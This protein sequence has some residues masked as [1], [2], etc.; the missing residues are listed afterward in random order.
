MDLPKTLSFVNYAV[1]GA[2]VGHVQRLSA[3]NR[4]LRRYATFLG[5]RSQH[6]FLTTSEA[7]TWLFAEN[8]AAF[9]LPS[10]SIVEPAG[11]NKL[12]YLAMAKQWV[13]TAM[14][15]LRPD[16]FLVDT[17]PNGSF[18]E[19]VPALD[20]CAKKALILRPVRPEIME[21]PG[22]RALV[23]LYDRVVVPSDLE[24]P[25]MTLPVDPL[26]VGPILLD[27]RF[28]QHDR[29]EARR[30]LGVEGEAFC[31]LVSGGGGG[32]PGVPALFE[33]MEAVAANDP[34]IH[35]LFAAGPLSRMPPRR[36]ARRTWW[37]DPGLGQ[38]LSGVDAAISAAGFNSV[39][40]LLHAGVPSAFLPQRKIADDQEARAQAVVA[41]GAGLRLASANP[42]ELRSVLARL[43]DSAHARWMSEQARKTVPRNAARDVAAVLLEMYV[44]RAQVRQA[45][46]VLDDALLGE[47]RSRGIALGDLVDV[48]IALGAGQRPRD[49]S[50]LDLDA[51]LAVVRAVDDLPAASLSRLTSLF[52]RK[53]VAA[54]CAPSRMGQSLVRMLSHP[55][56]KG[57]W[58]A[59]ASLLNVWP[60]TRDGDP[61][62]A[63]DVLLG[64]VDMAAMRGLG[65]SRLAQVVVQA[66]GEEEVGP[67]FLQRVRARLEAMA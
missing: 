63:T 51:A 37:T 52:G 29:A 21:R 19:L 44:P 50:E 7:D 32:D 25:P 41:A 59:L 61:D 62:R 22:F 67:L 20:L 45:V 66:Q 53:L 6:W 15:T 4:W 38:V 56:T 65:V 17:F 30:R 11:I 18:D 13:W 47:A 49:R 5:I 27:E 36:G 24:S 23:G 58:S 55:A 46:D 35:L 57:Q 42:D 60:Q 48:A 54:E 33:A 9:K 1:N 14:S 12:Q 3:I 10:K 43:R 39:H 2:G 31:V 28:E 8:F 16:L 26:R 40:E 34:S 64:L